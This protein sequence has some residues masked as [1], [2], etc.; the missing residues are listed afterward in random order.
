MERT[1]LVTGSKVSLSGVGRALERYGY[2]VSLAGTTENLG[3]LAAAMPP[4]SLSCYVQLPFDTDVEACTPVGRL[5]QFY[6]TALNDR[7]QAATSVAPLLRADA[8]VALVAGDEVPDGTPDDPHARMGLLRLIS[9][10]LSAGYGEMKSVVLDAD[11]S[12]EEIAF[13]AARNGE[14]RSWLHSGVRDI[15]GNVNFAEWRQELMGLS[16]EYGVGSGLSA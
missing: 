13:L 8:L 16:P 12:P 4:A 1:A 15:P 3:D 9:R 14:D 5:G 6:V 10:A 2:A 7:L 11:R